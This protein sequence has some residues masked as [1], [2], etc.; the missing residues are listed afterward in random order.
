MI[1]AMAVVAWLQPEL[2]PL[3]TPTLGAIGAGIAISGISAAISIGASLLVSA[4]APPPTPKMSKL[5]GSSAGGLESQTLSI[6]GTQYRA[7]PYGVI[8]RV[9]GAFRMFPNISA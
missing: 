3:L 1:A 9:Y 4:I 2:F 7:N 5:N 8:P 6:A